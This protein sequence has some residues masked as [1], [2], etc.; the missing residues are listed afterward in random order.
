[1]LRRGAIVAFAVVV[2]FPSVA[3]AQT[4]LGG[5]FHLV[6]QTHSDGFSKPLGGT[7]RGGSVIFGAQVSRRLAVEIE[8]SFEG[9][10]SWTY[11][12]RPGPS[13]IA[14]VVARRHEAFFSVQF[15]TRVGVFEPVAGVT[16]IYGR[17]SRHAVFRGGTPYFDDS[18]SVNGVA[19]VGGLDAAVKCNSHFFFVPTFRLFARLPGSPDDPLAE[20]TL[21]G[22]FTF[23]YG[24]GARVTF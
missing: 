22:A 1:M 23:R 17:I 18:R 19:A 24:A 6:T 3:A 12:Y 9:P 20:Q 11:T 13:S 7:T 10:Y 5:A 8:P 16:Y 14:D 4:Y 2:V 21:T 15:R